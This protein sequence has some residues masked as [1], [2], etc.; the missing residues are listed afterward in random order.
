VSVERWELFAKDERE[1]G[2]IEVDGLHIDEEEVWK[3]MIVKQ[4]AHTHEHLL[5][6]HVHQKC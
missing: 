3:V 1:G 5:W 2:G 4:V 6:L